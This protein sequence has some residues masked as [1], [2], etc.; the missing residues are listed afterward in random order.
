MSRSASTQMPVAL[1]TQAAATERPPTCT[2]RTCP[3]SRSRPVT[4]AWFS[5]TAPRAIAVRASV[6]AS[7]ASSNWASQ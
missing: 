4:G 1:T 5:T 6:T 3:F 2:P 7:R